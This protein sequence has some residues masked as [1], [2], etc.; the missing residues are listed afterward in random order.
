MKFNKKEDF[1]NRLNPNH[2]LLYIQREELSNKYDEK[3]LKVVNNKLIPQFLKTKLIAKM[4][5][6]V[7]LCDLRAILLRVPIEHLTADYG[8]KEEKITEDKKNQM[9]DRIKKAVDTFDIEEKDEYNIYTL[10]FKDNSGND[11]E[12]VFRKLSTEG[13]RENKLLLINKRKRSLPL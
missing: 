8:L 10:K 5:K 1:S 9:I 6:E 12:I 11:K 13:E 7:G 3:F 4:D 2:E